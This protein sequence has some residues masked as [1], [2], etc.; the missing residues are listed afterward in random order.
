VVYVKKKLPYSLV[1]GSFIGLW[2]KYRAY[3]IFL[4]Q[5]YIRWE[6]NDREKRIGD[7]YWK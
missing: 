6:N 3:W 1:G 4:L 7:S 5:A 2:N